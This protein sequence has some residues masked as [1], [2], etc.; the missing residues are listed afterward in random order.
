[1][2]QEKIG[3]FIAKLRKEKNMTQNELAQRLGITD[4]AIS[5]WENGR[6]MPDLSLL[7]PLCE[8]LDVSI[9]GTVLGY[10]VNIDRQVCINAVYKYNTSIVYQIYLVVKD[11]EIQTPKYIEYD[12]ELNVGDIYQISADYRWPSTTIQNFTWT[13]SDSSVALVSIWGTIRAQ[14]TGT[15]IVQGH[16][17]LNERYYIILRINVI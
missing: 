7:T 16:Y 12:L 8:I 1:M 11:E 5:K 15:V 4:R 6:G 13:T 14:E 9:Y 3:K 10:N 17:L 2:D